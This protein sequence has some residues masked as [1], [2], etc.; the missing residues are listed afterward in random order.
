LNAILNEKPSLLGVGTTDTVDNYFE[1]QA[2][3]VIAPSY[4]IIDVEAE[5][6]VIADLISSCLDHSSLTAHKSH[7]LQGSVFEG[8]ILQGL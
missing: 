5:R 1:K 3:R 8:P 4:Q 7:T 2:N 6:E